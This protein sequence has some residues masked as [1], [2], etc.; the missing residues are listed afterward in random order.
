MGIIPA[1]GLCHPLRATR[2]GD[3]CR[4]RRAIRCLE[5]RRCRAIHQCRAIH[6][7]RAIRREEDRREDFPGTRG[8]APCRDSRLGIFG[9]EDSRLEMR[10]RD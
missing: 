9:R 4:R 2:R 6:R 3:S 8:S 7:C 10:L 5:C 1:G